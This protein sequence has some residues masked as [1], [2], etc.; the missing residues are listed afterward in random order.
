MNGPVGALAIQTEAGGIERDAITAQDVEAR[1]RMYR[2][3]SAMYLC[4]PTP[5]LLQRIVAEDFLEALASLFDAGAVAELR[6]FA[7]SDRGGGDLASLEREYMDL[8][9]VPTDRYVTPF[10]DVYWGTTVD[11]QAQRGP[12]LGERAVAV[13]RR[14]R[15]AAA[16]MAEACKELPTHIGVELS[17]M[18]FLCEREAE[19]FRSGG[20]TP[21]DEEERV[22]G[23]STQYRDLQ[24]QFLQK[25]L[26]VWFPQLSRAIQG[27]ARTG[28]YRG[29]ARITEEFL[30]W[31]AASL[32]GSRR[33]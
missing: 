17:F 15:E 20:S 12:L 22:N 19:A 32:T 5:E 14:Y 1:G 27:C 6:R 4:P 7:T 23:A 11:G 25:H 24:L 9:A 29:F 18:N 28:L 31:D 13:I 16:D 21:P 8:F 30:R 33:V 26:N 10:E 3:L 2:F